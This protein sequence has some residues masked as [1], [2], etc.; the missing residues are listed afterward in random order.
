MKKQNESFTEPAKVLNPE[1]LAD[2]P[3]GTV[4]IVE[5][6]GGGS[7]PYVVERVIAKGEN[8]DLGQFGK[9]EDAHLFA[10]IY[11]CVRNLL[12]S[13]KERQPIPANK[14]EVKPL[15]NTF[16]RWLIGAKGDRVEILQPPI[17]LSADD[18]FLAAA[19]LVCV[20]ECL[21]PSHSFQEV[22]DAVVNT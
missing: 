16:N 22:L 13:G 15:I 2:L 8:E 11:N 4:I 10:C 1:D 7:F 18:A 9:K 19:W 5:N 21:K 20:A 17:S 3:I 6:R 12:E 14:D